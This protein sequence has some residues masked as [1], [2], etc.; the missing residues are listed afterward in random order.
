MNECD[1]TR[2]KPSHPTS[3][4]CNIIRL[5]T[6]NN[7][8]KDNETVFLFEIYYNF[9]DVFFS[10]RMG[11]QCQHQQQIEEE[12]TVGDNIVEHLFVLLVF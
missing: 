2:L 1:A 5:S 10:K 11:K 9:I 6:R 4:W 8:I 3:C 7:H 12:L